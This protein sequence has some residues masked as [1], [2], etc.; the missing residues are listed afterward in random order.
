MIFINK[1]LVFLTIYIIFNSFTKKIIQ[2]LLI[3]IRAF[4]QIKFCYI[5][6]L[7]PNTKGD[8]LK[9]TPKIKNYLAI[10]EKFATV[11]WK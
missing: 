2:I 11:F 5:K 1:I 4:F 8:K 7:W 10:L 9:K 6:E 3:L